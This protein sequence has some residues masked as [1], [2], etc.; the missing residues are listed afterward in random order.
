MDRIIIENVRCFRER[1]EVPLAP[2]TLLVG[3]NSTGKSTFLALTRAVWDI[4]TQGQANFN[5]EPFLLGAYNQIAS[6]L[7]KRS[8]PDFLIGW[9]SEFT[10][11]RQQSIVSS[12]TGRFISSPSHQP[13]L[14]TWRCEAPS[15]VLEAE[16]GG[17]ERAISIRA[18]APSGT[19]KIDMNFWGLSPTRVNP[20][21]AATILEEMP[22]GVSPGDVRRFIELAVD[23]SDRR[24]SRPYAFAPIR[25]RP[26]RTYDPVKEV[27]D[28]EGG[29]VPL[30]LAGIRSRDKESWSE[31]RSVLDKFGRASGLFGKVE[32]RRL[33]KNESDPFQ[34]QVV[35][36]GT[37]NN[38]LDV[39]YGVS[40][41][42]P[43]LVDCVRG[44]VEGTFLLQQ[45]EIHLH[46]KSV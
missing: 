31:L 42:L 36:D 39:G 2:L 4:A 25:T 21:W 34:L 11:G 5:E 14:K 7:G 38:L 15:L 22:G 45:P 18:Q 30:V 33:G 8:A 23:W 20:P 6:S 44:D 35:I 16:F 29:H 41:I 3:E 19:Q 10:I 13:S 40:Q 17:D 1:Q 46:P 26:L 37:A 32:V 43:I 12:I 9:S 27:I 28:P 24:G